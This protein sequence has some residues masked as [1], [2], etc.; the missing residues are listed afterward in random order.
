MSEETKCESL[1]EA[2]KH[3]DK[4]ASEAQLKIKLFEKNFEEMTGY[5]P[6]QSINALDVYKIF[7]R[8]SND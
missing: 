6:N 1:G 5:K 3:I 4:V 2:I 7:Q 8:L